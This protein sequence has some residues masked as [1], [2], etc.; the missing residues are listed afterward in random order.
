[1]TRH[2]LVLLAP[3]LVAAAAP[4]APRSVELDRI[5]AV[6][7]SEAITL[8][9]LRSRLTMVER[10]LRGQNIEMPPA[11]V[12]RSQVL[13]RMIIDRAQIQMARESGLRIDD[14]QVDRAIGGIAAQNRATLAEL[15][16]RIERDG[17]SFP[18]FRE[19]VRNEILITRLR[20]REVDQRVAISEA[21][22]DSLLAQ[23]G[24]KGGATSGTEFNLAHILL[25]VPENASAEQ[26]TRQRLRGEELLRQLGRGSDFGRLAAAFSDSP[27]AMS[28]GGMGWRPADRLPELFVTAVAP[29]KPGQLTTLLRSAN[30]FHIVKVLDRRD[31]DTP[32]LG[33]AP[34]QQT[35]ARHIL[36]LQ[37]ELVPEV[38]AVRRLR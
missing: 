5:V 12:L 1:M 21:D 33:V 24:D 29:L 19:D 22:I 34:V 13:E 15:R 35:H 23:S 37:T 18:S 17:T 26:I 20:E 2:L 8:F 32:K 4:A 7:N 14:S 9:E 10:Q 38:E 16:Q 6:V 30:G 28:G 36:V 25:R 11:D 31:S 3:L 27:E